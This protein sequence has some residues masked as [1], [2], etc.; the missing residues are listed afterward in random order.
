MPCRLI[1]RQTEQC[2]AHVENGLSASTV[3]SVVREPVGIRILAVYAGQ[4]VPTIMRT[5]NSTRW[6][7][8]LIPNAHVAVIPRLTAAT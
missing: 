1:H 2:A 7:S 4:K 5:L 3:V 6:R 8:V